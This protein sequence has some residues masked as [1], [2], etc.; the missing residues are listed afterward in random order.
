MDKH[1]VREKKK[2]APSELKWCLEN[3]DNF[4]HISFFNAH[5][6]NTKSQLIRRFNIIVNNWIVDVNKKTR[7]QN[8]FNSWNLTES[9]KFWKEWE[10]RRDLQPSPEAETSDQTIQ[11]STV[12]SSLSNATNELI[13]NHLPIYFSAPCCDSYVVSDFNVNLGFY[14]FQ[15]AVKEAIVNKRLLTFESNIAHILAVSAILLLHQQTNDSE[16]DR[17]LNGLSTVIIKDLKSKLGWKAAKFPRELVVIL[18]D[19]H[20]D[21]TSDKCT[22]EVAVTKISNLSLN[23]DPVVR[24][25][26]GVIMRLLQTLPQ[27]SNMLEVL[28]RRLCSR[29]LQPILQ[30]L[31]D[32]RVSNGEILFDFTDELL[33]KDTDTTSLNN[34]RPDGTITWVAGNSQRHL[35]YIEVKPLSAAGSHYLVNADL[36]RLGVFAKKTIDSNQCKNLLVIQAVGMMLTFYM[37]QRTTEELY[38]MVELD[39]IRF[40]SSIDEM[41]MIFGAMDKIMDIISIFRTCCIDNQPCSTEMHKKTLSSP[42]LRAITTDNVNRK[43]KNPY[44]QSYY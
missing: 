6:Q 28:E 12:V 38:T 35:G 41:T 13:I 30:S 15:L 42:I 11:T 18:L 3:T 2:R 24:Q 7:L 5:M 8:N 20:H 26:L 32:Q 17:Y 19:I 25:C 27:I 23:Y 44:Q 39:R 31:F 16:L 33:E 14:N 21:L 34:R 4:D 37:V 36:V 40:P 22:K 9:K 10:V 29:Y 43:R 1:L